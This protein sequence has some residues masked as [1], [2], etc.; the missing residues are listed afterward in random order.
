MVFG[1]QLIV[2]V[3][4]VEDYELLNHIDT[5][6]PLMEKI[7]KECN[8]SVVGELKHQF[9]PIGVTIVYLLE[10][11]H[12]S[13]HTYPEKRACSIDLY[14]C[15]TNTDFHKALDIIYNF[16]NKECFILKKIIVR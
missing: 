8:L 2:D 15:N 13:I 12:L 16:F 3:G 5:I 1:R 4:N 6:K 11:S 10:E 7:I 9:Y 14:S